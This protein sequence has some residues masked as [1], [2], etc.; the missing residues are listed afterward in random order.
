MEEDEK[1]LNTINR[2][3][4][5]D[6]KKINIELK[7]KYKQFNNNYNIELQ[8][9]LIVISGVNGSGKTQLMDIISQS[10][11]LNRNVSKI[12]LNKYK[13][14]SEIK[15]DG[16]MINNLLIS[17]RSFKDNINISN[18]SLPEPK[19]ILWHKDEAWK[20]FSNYQSW[21]NAVN[22][23]KSKSIVME[24][25]KD[26]VIPGVPKFDSSKPNNTNTGIDEE[27][28][29]LLLPDNFVW[30]PDD[31]F[32]NSIDKIF[33]EFAAKRHDEQARLGRE[34]GGFNNE[35]YLVNAPWTI[36]NRLFERLKF[37]YRFKDD[38]EF[39]TPN[40]KERPMLYPVL[41][42]NTLDYNSP[43]E[44]SDLS[45][46]EKAIISLTFAL[47]NENRRPIEKILLLDEFD[48][49]L[50]PSLI[51]ALFTVIDEFFVSKG[52]VVIMTTHSP[53]T[54]SL[55][56]NYASYYEIFKQD[57]ESPKII[58]VDRYQYGELKVANQNFYSKLENQDKRIKELE[59]ENKILSSNKVLFVE[60][61]YISIYK[62]AWLKINGLD[63][64]ID[65]LD[66]EFKK[67]SLF[68]ICSKGNKDNL[69][70][71]LANPYMDEWNGKNI[72]GL[73]DF[74]DAYLCFKSITKLTEE[75]LK[76]ENVSGDENTGLYSRR[77]KYVNVSALMLPVPDYRRDIANKD[78]SINKLEVEL[79]FK[80]E[81]IEKMYGT[82]G[83]SKE[84]VIGNIEIPKI[85]NKA[86]FW[87]KAI[88]LPKEK[89]EGFKPL[90]KM[91]N[92]LLEIDENF[93]LEEKT[94]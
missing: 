90:F 38:Y 66:E 63:P 79:L 7:Q 84:K 25:L 10:S 20:C 53:V 83:Y 26:Q 34:N 73:F 18:I 55:A 9:D 67:Y 16:E 22:F 64:T 56:P 61:K 59:E 75:Q 46:G 87:K 42:N 39:L 23:N 74:D 47:L 78:Q 85:N 91:V 51:E 27:K 4:G 2:N 29:K 5:N 33:Y 41:T 43:R 13:I 28:F 60:D 19:N 31:L 80:D 70:G 36:L 8:G 35:E 44:L 65:N 52:V 11:L 15:I 94:H 24:C 93:K 32:T 17:R 82:E 45:D 62:L 49:T 77:K 86:N 48:N 68:D 69:K 37:N 12:D 76:W 81:D 88:D 54:I 1:L 72:V 58:P 92:E 40:L 50:N 89:F 57:N 3:R 30:V 6:M 21:D 71:F 14:I